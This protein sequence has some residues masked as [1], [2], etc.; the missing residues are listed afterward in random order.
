MA[1]ILPHQGKMGNR[2]VI[3][4]IKT[5]A[6]MLKGPEMLF[7]LKSAFYN[8]DVVDNVKAI[9]SG[10]TRCNIDDTLFPKSVI[11]LLTCEDHFE[12]HSKFPENLSKHLSK[13]LSK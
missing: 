4:M 12:C 13:N 5:L 1:T 8:C 7:E 9:A 3:M 11:N 6:D 10:P 2:P